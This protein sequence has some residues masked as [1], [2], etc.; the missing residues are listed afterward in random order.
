MRAL[1]IALLLGAVLVGCAD[2]GEEKRLPPTRTEVE[3]FVHE[4]VAYARERGKEA[5]LAEFTSTSPLFHRG[6][7]YIYAYD[8]N[9]VN[10]AH[11]LQPELVGR[12]LTDYRDSRGLLV[13]QELAKL[14]KKGQGW[15]RFYWKSPETGQDAAKLGYVMKVDDTWWLGSGTYAK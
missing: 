9:C 6:Q 13:I 4:A 8:F 5:A 1:G 15:L 11:G 10:L 2:V 14:A 12:D 7:L 3:E